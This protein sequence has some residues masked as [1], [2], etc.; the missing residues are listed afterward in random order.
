[1]VEATTPTIFAMPAGVGVNSKPV[2]VGYRPVIIIALD[3]A[4]VLA[5]E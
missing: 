4:Q 1:M 3:G 2:R 5:P